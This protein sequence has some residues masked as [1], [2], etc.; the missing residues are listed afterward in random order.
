[1]ERS[2]TQQSINN[3]T[4]MV[5]TRSKSNLKIVPTT[6]TTV[7]TIVTK[8]TNA[9]NATKTKTNT[10]IQPIQ[11]IQPNINSRVTTKPTKSAKPAETVVDRRITR[12]CSRNQQ[13]QDQVVKSNSNSNSNSKSKSKSKKGQQAVQE[14]VQQKSP[15]K[16][17]RDQRRLNE[18]MME[19]K[20]L[21]KVSSL[22]VSGKRRRNQSEH[23]DAAFVLASLKQ[24][25]DA[26]RKGGLVGGSMHH[27]DRSY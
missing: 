14:T 22:I 24:T 12:S 10:S 23:Q 6:A 2:R 16:L 20:T 7:A 15:K 17:T 25:K 4:N 21:G 26:G 3:T 1:M 5:T 27:Y 9:T 13:Q 11:P 18:A 8:I 19:L